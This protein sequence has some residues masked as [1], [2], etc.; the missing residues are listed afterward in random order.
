MN[1]G[2]FS[3]APKTLFV[4]TTNPAQKAA[5]SYSL[6]KPAGRWR[7]PSGQGNGIP[8]STFPLAQPRTTAR[9]EALPPQA[10][11]RHGGKRSPSPDPA[12]REAPPLLLG[13][14][15]AGQ[16]AP[17]PRYLG[18]DKALVGGAVAVLR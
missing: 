11:A 18:S 8:Q 12:G 9:R 16:A 7:D 1:G 5:G 15:S 10:Q 14:R 17:G 3:L 13:V 6:G 4:S 2:T